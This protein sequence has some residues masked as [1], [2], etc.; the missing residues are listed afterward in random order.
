[1]IRSESTGP[2]QLGVSFLIDYIRWT[3]LTPMIVLWGFF[4]FMLV[5]MVFV[6]NQETVFETLESLMNWVVGLPLIGEIVSRWIDAVVE[7]SNSQPS[8]DGALKLDG[9]AFE[10]AVMKV[11]SFISLVLLL[12]SLVIS[13]IFGPFNPWTLKRKLGTAAVACFF[14]VVGFTVVYLIDLEMFRGPA[15]Q[16]LLMFMGIGVLLFAVCCW[17]LGI[18]HFLEWLRNRITSTNSIRS[19]ETSKQI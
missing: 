16:W 1:M 11:W 17:S 14:L 15:Y 12:L 10:A 9:K 5:A 13:W 3:Q 4:L 7:W 19:L 6:N 18:A 8:D 2:L